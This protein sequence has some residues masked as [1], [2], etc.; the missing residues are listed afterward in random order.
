MVGADRRFPSS[1][2]C[3][4]CG[5]VQKKMPLAVLRVAMSGLWNPS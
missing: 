3:S 1:K 5:T 2:S 4:T